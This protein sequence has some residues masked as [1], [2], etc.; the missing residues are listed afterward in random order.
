MSDQYAKDSQYFLKIIDKEF[1]NNL[2]TIL[3][4]GFCV[5]KKRP[6]KAGTPG[7]KTSYSRNE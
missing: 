2:E 4:H 3:D 7:N 1:Q 5:T 6:E